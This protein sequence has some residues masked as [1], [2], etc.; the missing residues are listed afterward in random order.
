MDSILCELS[1]IVDSSGSQV[2]KGDQAECSHSKKRKRQSEQDS[3]QVDKDILSYLQE[4]RNQEAE[5]EDDIFFRSMAV[6]CKK[7]PPRAKSSVKFK[8]HKIIHEAELETFDQ[9][10]WTKMEASSNQTEMVG[11]ITV[12][13]PN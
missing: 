9:S 6:A 7:L 5:D 3:W 12:I 10:S 8:I 1:K 11:H 2:N 4:V 13:Q